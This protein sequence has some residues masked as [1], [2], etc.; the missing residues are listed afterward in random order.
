MIE[1]KIENEI[2]NSKNNDV[3]TVNE[4]SILN[5]FQKWV[6]YESLIFKIIGVLLFLVGIPLLFA[7]GA[8]FIYFILGIITFRQGVLLSASSKFSKNLSLTD[9]T[10]ILNTLKPLKDFFVIDSILKTL[11]LL[12]SI[13]SL[14]VGSFMIFKDYKSGNS[15]LKPKEQ[16]LLK[17]KTSE[18]IE[19]KNIKLKVNSIDTIQTEKNKIFKVKLDVS[20]LSNKDKF[21]SSSDFLIKDDKNNSISESGIQMN[22]DGM[23]PF[24]NKILAP[25][26]DTKIDLYYQLDSSAKVKEINFE[27]FNENDKFT[28]EIE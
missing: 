8:G 1:T 9:N 16:R 2:E 6:N 17:K 7:Y 18:T 22:I 21:I 23:K 25:E 12:L 3:I 13:F 27:D 11:V 10:E 24:T 19:N 4:I 15:N 14:I 28:F 5:S 26:N 20:N